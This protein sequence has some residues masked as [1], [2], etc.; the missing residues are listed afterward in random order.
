MAAK[1]IPLILTLDV[2]GTPHRWVNYEQAAYYYAK[3]LIAWSLGGDDYTIW[4]GTQRMSGNR[5]SLT[6]NTII[7][8]RGMNNNKKN[9]A[10]VPP[11]TNRALFRRDKNV[12]AYC[13]HEFNCNDLTRDHVTPVSKGGPDDW[14]NVVAACG[15]CNRHKSDK[16][17][18]Q[19]GMKLI[20]VPY[21]PNRSEYLILMNRRVLA[22][23]MEYLMKSVPKTSRLHA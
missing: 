3:D 23:Q 2:T 17:P 11:L 15:G 12:C 16:T 5:S 9:L 6:M 13:G 18:D 7:A 14:R 20:Y 19:A 1:D 4:G 10:A 8:I 22:D 21:A